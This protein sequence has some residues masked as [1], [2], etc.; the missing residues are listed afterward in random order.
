VCAGHDGCDWEAFVSHEHVIRLRCPR[1]MD[2][3]SIPAE[4]YAVDV[5]L[6][7]NCDGVHRLGVSLGTCLCGSELRVIS[8]QSA[9]PWRRA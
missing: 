7:L 8:H 4:H 9:D 1:D 5:R 6:P 2:D 3:P